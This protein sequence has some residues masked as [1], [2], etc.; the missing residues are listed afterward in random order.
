MRHLRPLVLLALATAS[1]LIAQTSKPFTLQQALSAPYATDLTA[2]PVGNLFAWVED[3]EG[4]HNLYV[5]GKEVAARQLTSNTEDDAQDISQ[6]AWSPDAKLIAYTYGAPNGADGKPA[7]PAHL[8][9][10]TPVQVIVQPLDANAKSLI[11]GEGRAPLFSRDGKSLFFLRAGQIFTACLSDCHPERS[12]QRE[13]E[14][15]A[16]PEPPQSPTHQLVFDRGTAS[17]LTLSPDGNTLAFISRRREVNQPSHSFLA[18][19]DLKT[20]TLSFPAPSTGDDSAPAFSPD[21]KQLAWIRTPFT[22]IPEFANPRTSATPWSIQLLDITSANLPKHVEGG[23][24]NPEFV[25]C[26]PSFTCHPE[27]SERP[28][29]SPGSRTIYQP[30]PNKPGSVLP[31][32]GGHDPYLVWTADHRVIFAGNMDGWTHLY[33]AD[34]RSGKG[35]APLTPGEFDVTE[36]RVTPDGFNV[37]YVSNEIEADEADADRSHVRLATFV[38]RDDIR[39]TIPLTIGSG[40]ET[41]LYAISAITENMPA[42][43]DAQKEYPLAF[44]HLNLAT[45]AADSREPM[46][47]VLIDGARRMKNLHPVDHSSLSETAFVTPQQVLFPSTDSLQIHGQLFLPKNLDPKTKHPAILFFHGGPMRQML[48]GYPAMGYYSNAYAMNQYLTS[49]GFIVLSVNY[50]CGIGY[51]LD[52]HQCEGEGATGAKEYNDVLAAQKYLAS[53]PDVDVKRIGVWGGSYGGYLTA[54]ALARNSDLFAAGV[55]FHGVHDWNL[56][57]NASD[58]KRGSFAQQDAIAAKAL[59]SSPLADLSKWHSPILLIHG[60]NDG[61]VAYAQTPLLADALR[62]RNASLPADQ[63]VDVEELIF[64]DEI[65]EFLL[66]STWLKAYTAAAEFFERTLKP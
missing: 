55:D 27:L 4:R 66:H 56:E 28:A 33:A 44:Y 35:A 5:G 29:L 18:L 10:S 26:I 54:L 48:L 15:T 11:V 65:H 6:L 57:D 61:N 19:L 24:V 12:A 41:H 37:L 14:G 59:Q 51:G 39:G 58:W 34:T 1:S 17:A 32:P 8:Q 62:A 21:G 50:R 16:L 63:K 45:L 43:E 49:R 46:H 31:D 20:H 42:S 7:N 13:V 38:H 53:R 22:D 9:R 36:F 40:I 47:P 2:A 23:S 30:T 60:D 25:P 3:A 64:P 52:F